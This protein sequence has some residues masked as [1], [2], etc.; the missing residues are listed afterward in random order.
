VVSRLDVD[1]FVD[2]DLRWLRASFALDDGILP[3]HPNESRDLASGHLRSNP[4]PL[5]ELAAV[6]EDVQSLFSPLR[7]LVV[8][9][10]LLFW[11][12]LILASKI[13]FDY[14]VDYTS[15]P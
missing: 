2:S 11:H 8:A 13:L 1:P 7:G 15:T 6:D 9:T 4:I 14:D 10:V 3:R 5:V 12:R